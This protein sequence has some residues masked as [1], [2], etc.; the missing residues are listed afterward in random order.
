M[1]DEIAVTHPEWMLVAKIAFILASLAVSYVAYK[2]GYGPEYRKTATRTKAQAY[3]HRLMRFF[4]SMLSI[5]AVIAAGLTTGFAVATG[6][7]VI[8]MLPPYGVG[9]LAAWWFTR[10]EKSEAFVNSTTS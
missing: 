5:L 8:L 2:T 4:G 10:N 7:L 9:T 1:M 3:T 6:V